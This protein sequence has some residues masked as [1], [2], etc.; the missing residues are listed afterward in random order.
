M[1]SFLDPLL[2]S[3]RRFRLVNLTTGTLVADTLE[4][5]FDSAG[6]KKGLLGRQG[7]ESGRALILAPCNAVHTFFMRF[8]ID[9]VLVGR[10]GRVVKVCHR[11]PPWRIALALSAFATIELPAGTAQAANVRPGDTVTMEPL[12]IH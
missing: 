10:D 9:V 5:A 7:F 4:T 12:D 8:P 11:V 1:A 6:R 3:H 2:D